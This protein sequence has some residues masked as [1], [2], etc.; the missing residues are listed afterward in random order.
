MLL[1]KAM[2]VYVRECLSSYASV[3]FVVAGTPPNRHSRGGSKRHVA[4]AACVVPCASC[5]VLRAS[6]AQ[7][8][9]REHVAWPLQ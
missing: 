4:S 3:R 1:V 8:P 2:C 7:Y 9:G 6:E 5:F